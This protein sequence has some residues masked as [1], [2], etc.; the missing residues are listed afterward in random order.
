M[1]Q[2]LKSVILPMDDETV[3]HPGHGPSTTIARERRS[4]PYLLELA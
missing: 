3:I 4:N 1:E 2:T